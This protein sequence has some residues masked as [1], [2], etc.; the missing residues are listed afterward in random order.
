MSAERYKKIENRFIE[1][2]SRVFRKL[3][4][5]V[6]GAVSSFYNT[7]RQKFTVM[8]VPHSEKKVV[9][10][11]ISV[12]SLVF[13]LFVTLSV[14]GTFFVYTTR[15]SGVSQQLAEKSGSLDE[16]EKN[17]D[18]LLDQVSDLKRASRNFEISLDKAMENLN[19]SSDKELQASVVDGDFS[20]LISANETDAG[21]M[22]EISELENLAAY[23]EDSVESFSKIT[24]LI[25]SQGDLLVEM[26]TL[27]PVE[28]GDGRITN[29]FGP[30]EHPFTHTWYLHKGIDIGFGFGKPILAAANGKIV[31]RGYEPL[32]FGNYIVIRHNYGFITKYAHLNDVYVDEGDVITQGQVI[33]AMGST[34]LSTG[35][36]LHFEIRIGSQV[37]DPEKFLNV[38]KR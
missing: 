4:N 24:E 22:R 32:G 14:L 10:F 26:P 29:Y 25:I 7:G 28:G 33:G 21:V 37:V 35:P 31:E 23:L 27:W 3:F 8:L 18:L 36:H 12:F 19:I 5:G 6:G 15:I 20:S 13:I 38:R 9:N 34:G 2:L 16:S 1:T 30:A 11:R 17:L